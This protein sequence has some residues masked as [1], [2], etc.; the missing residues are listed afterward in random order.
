MTLT[1][2]DFKL[3]DQT[4]QRMVDLL[5]DGISVEFIVQGLK[6]HQVRPALT[7]Y[8][9]GPVVCCQSGLKVTPDWLSTVV[10]VERLTAI[11]TEHRAGNVGQLA[12]YADVLAY[13]YPAAS[14]QYLPDRWTV[15]Y[16]YVHDAILLRHDLPA[17]ETVRQTNCLTPG[18]ETRLCELRQ[19]LRRTIVRLARIREI[20]WPGRPL[21]LSRNE[22][23]FQQLARCQLEPTINLNLMQE[24]HKNDSPTKNPST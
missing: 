2:D 10:R 11:I 16:D 23:S 24:K 4:V 21:S 8:L 14:A 9:K 20:V 6:F 7:H 12:N 18:D 3:N 15:I 5:Q 1:D 22:T 17:D 19:D 13:L